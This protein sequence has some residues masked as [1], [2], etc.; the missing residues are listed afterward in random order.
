[1]IGHR[2]AGLPLGCRVLLLANVVSSLCGKTALAAVETAAPSITSV[3]TDADATS[4]YGLDGSF[5]G[6]TK[7]VVSRAMFVTEPSELV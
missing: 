6:G 4:S 2:S 5:A 1:M 3:S 7:C